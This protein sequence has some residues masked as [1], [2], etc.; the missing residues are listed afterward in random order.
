VLSVHIFD[1]VQ[2]EVVCCLS[3]LFPPTPGNK[4][5]QC[6]VCSLETERGHPVDFSQN[7]TSWSELVEGDCICEYC[8]TLCRD[9]KYRRKSWIA[10]LKGIRFLSRKDVLPVLLDPPEPPFAVYVTKSG[11][12]QGFLHILNKVALSRDT[13]FIAFEDRAVFVDRPTL[14]EMYDLA[15]HCV[16][17]LKFKKSYLVDPPVKCW[18]YREECEMIMRYRK[19]PL[20]EVV[21]YAI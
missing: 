12:K 3:R 10:T 1:M 2:Q 17:D 20:W 9:Q 11:K 18:K 16:N 5:G 8:Y 14:K 15:F 7:F 21:V 4:R 6:V 19:N 13:F